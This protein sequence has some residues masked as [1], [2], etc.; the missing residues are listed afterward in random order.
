VEGKQRKR[1]KKKEGEG[2]SFCQPGP[3]EVSRR[4]GGLRET[5]LEKGIKRSIRG[6]FII[7]NGP[8]LFPGRGQDER[9]RARC[10]LPGGTGGEKGMTFSQRSRRRDICDREKGVGA[11]KGFFVGTKLKVFTWGMR[12]GE[13]SSY[14]G[15]GQRSRKE[16]TS[17]SMERNG[18][19]TILKLNFGSMKNAA[20]SQR[21]A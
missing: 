18:S 19:T 16:G 14:R 9:E 10:R 3:R 21:N 12:G 11:E 2:L 7:K 20:Q 8:S 1:A 13:D 5:Q 6:L 15:N 17:I 4:R